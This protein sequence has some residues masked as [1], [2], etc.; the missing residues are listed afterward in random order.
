MHHLTIHV[1]LARVITG[2]RLILGHF[3]IYILCKIVCG[4]HT[5]GQSFQR[6]GTYG[7]NS[8]VHRLGE[9]CLSAGPGESWILVFLVKVKGKC[10][11]VKWDIFYFIHDIDF[12]RWIVRVCSQRSRYMNSIEGL[13]CGRFLQDKGI[14]S[15]RITE[16]L[17]SDNVLEAL[18]QKIVSFSPLRITLLA[19]RCDVPYYDHMQ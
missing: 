12:D 17:K 19:S 8:K 14:L 16:G 10:V 9:G 1:L 3:H 5:F 6:R 7:G 2:C 4:Q 13:T 15:L 18:N 11:R